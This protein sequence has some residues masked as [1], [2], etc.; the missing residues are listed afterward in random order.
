MSF[1]VGLKYLREI[2]LVRKGLRMIEGQEK[3]GKKFR[4]VKR[5]IVRQGRRLRGGADKWR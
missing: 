5:K 2:M 1:S 3:A 4:T